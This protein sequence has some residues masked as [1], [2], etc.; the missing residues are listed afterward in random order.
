MA[1]TNISLI[2]TNIGAVRNPKM[3]LLRSADEGV[4]TEYDLHTRVPLQDFTKLGSF[5]TASGFGENLVAS[6][7]RCCELC[8]FARPTGSH[9]T[10]LD[11]VKI[12]AQDRKF[13]RRTSKTPVQ[14]T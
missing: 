5:G 14:V 2:I 6:M 12:V 7:V 10:S 4:S 3:P 13:M 9:S 11:A 1:S 8:L